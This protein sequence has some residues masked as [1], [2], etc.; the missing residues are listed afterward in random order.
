MCNECLQLVFRARLPM[1]I[2]DLLQ[3]R[4]ME[5]INDESTIMHIIKLFL[6]GIEETRGTAAPAFDFCGICGVSL[7]LD[8][9]R[10]SPVT[11]KL[12]RLHWRQDLEFNE[13]RFSKA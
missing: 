7:L 13:E 3:I 1:C 8:F 4:E 5:S 2:R 12:L 6:P 9:R 10:N 11:N